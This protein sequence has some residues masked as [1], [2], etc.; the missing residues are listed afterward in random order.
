MGNVYEIYKALNFLIAYG[1]RESVRQA[2]ERSSLLETSISAIESLKEKKSI[3]ES[4]YPS[5]SQT[6]SK[7]TEGKAES[8]VHDETKL[9]KAIE[10]VNSVKL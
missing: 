4:I 7:D 10:M 6:Y 1:Q 2:R 3:L 5:I 9:K 8:W